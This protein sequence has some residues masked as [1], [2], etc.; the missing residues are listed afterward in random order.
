MSLEFISLENIQE[1]AHQYG[2]WAIFLGI[3][4]ENLG[5]PLPGET[6]TLVGGFL[7]G[8]DE[9]S[10]WL[11]VGDAVAGA[12]I[13]GAC[14]YWIGRLGGWPFLL[15]IGKI[16]RISEEKLLN[17]KEQFSQNA[18]KAVFFGR[19]FAL[20]RIFAAPLAGIAEI[21]FPKFFLYNLAGATTW[22]AVMVTLAFFAGRVISLEQLVAWVSQFAIAAL[23]ILVAVIV[24][25]LWLES[26][27]VK[28]AA[29]E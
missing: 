17:I 22:A 10:Y 27:Q 23:L 3:L 2:Y 1:F 5:I 9:L 13:G 6:V 28:R 11:V 24:I 7:A 14:G 12:M 18:I 8:S 4:L 29:G 26:R 21:P 15:Q 20:L 25:P 16:F 19:F